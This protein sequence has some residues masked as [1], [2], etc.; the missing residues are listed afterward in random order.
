MIKHFNKYLWKGSYVPTWLEFAHDV[1]FHE[2]KLTFIRRRG[3]R[4]EER[5][6][7]ERRERRG[8]N[9]SKSFIEE[10]IRP[11]LHCH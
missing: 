6:K 1:V 4:G 3:R 2:L 7:R 9:C 10:D 11:P 8:N 5:K